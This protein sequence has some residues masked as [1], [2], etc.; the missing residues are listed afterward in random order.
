MTGGDM[1][2]F[3]RCL[4]AFLV[5]TACAGGQAVAADKPDKVSFYF[6]AHEDDWQLFM[7]PSAFQDVTEAAAKTVFVHV[8]AGDAGLGTGD[9]GR[10]RPYYLA[11]ENGAEDA[12]RFMADT[13]H[14][15]A[16]PVVSHVVLNNHR[17]FR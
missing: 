3:R 8:T 9:G 1:T 6:A 2:A 11:R 7:N 10:K 17:I 13:D 5:V 14:E 16:K 4:Q 12:I 15:P